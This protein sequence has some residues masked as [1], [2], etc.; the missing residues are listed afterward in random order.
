VL[1][2][3]SDPVTPV[4]QPYGLPA[5]AG[6][7]ENRRP[8]PLD[9]RE[10]L[11]VLRRRLWIV[12]TAP[13]VL[14]VLAAV[15]VSVVTPLYT[16]TSTVLID[17]RRTNVDIGSQQVLTNFGTDEASNESQVLLIQSSAVLRRVVDTL[18]LTQD[19]EFAPAPG[20]L[21][22]IRSLLAR[23]AP[24]P[25]NA[26][27][28]RITKT[29]AALRAQVKV[30]RQRTT[31]LVDINVRSRDAAKATAIANAVADAYFL[32]QVRSKYEATKIAASWL[33]QQIEDVKNRVLATDKAVADFRN[34]NNLTES[35]GVTVTDQQITDLNNRLI[36]A[37]VQAAEARAKFEQ[38]QKIAS[39]GDDPGSVAEALSSDTIAQLRTRYADLAR[40]EADLST[41]YGARHPAVATARAQLRDTQR[42][43]S[44]EVQ[45]ILQG[46]RHIYEVA[47]AREASLQGSLNALQGV[48]NEA[49]QAQ[50]RLRELQREAQANRT[51][52]ESFLARYKEMSA[53]ESLEMPDSRIVTRASVPLQPSFPNTTLT[54]ALA[55]LV[56]LGLGSV[57][58]M[59][60]DYFDRR[61]KTFEQ[62]ETASGLTG[63]AAIP[64]IGSKDLAR[65]A[66]QGRHAL[67]DYD[68]K[69]TRLLPPALQPPLLRYA[70]EEPTSI[71]AESIRA[72]RLAVQRAGRAK[73]AQVVM[74]T[75]AI[76]GEGKTVVAANL[77]LSLAI[78]GVRT[79]L[80]DGDL[81]NPELT[82]ALC[83][84]AGQGLLEVATGEIPLHEAILTEPETRLSILPA[85][86]VRDTSLSTEFVFSEGM[87]NILGTLRQHFD[88]IIIDS[89]P[90]LP[91]VDGRALAEYADCIL[92][93][94]G[95][96]RTTEDLVMR[97][98]ELLDSV[99]HRILGAV[100]TRVD[101]AKL[102]LYDYSSPSYMTSYDYSIEARRGTAA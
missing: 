46:R 95:W 62:V 85:S 82:C 97:S 24:P 86:F 36:E 37:R 33:N 17:P 76:D 93:T 57:L 22:R 71:F 92:F 29:I 56:G 48:S 53:Q 58:A 38:V 13:L 65:L 40:N 66:K 26:E 19:P 5:L 16:A 51:L 3:S 44:D 39:A 52:Y 100:L 1:Q 91:L 81:R 47:A 55:L 96:D 78:V 18:N 87:E 90:L 14:L 45:R 11:R 41:R 80:V 83:P 99:Y 61:V 59:V 102:R 73:P 28:A 42:L 68:P 43:I 9:I 88:V 35:Q 54:L 20:L 6:Q 23:P 4:Q 101:L 98:V 2:R 94:V 70:I 10:I 75:S 34:A 63:L 77:A 21:D 64:Q 8:H 72:I 89:P 67:G 32:E 25:S 50:I 31:F 15:F 69:T 74:V 49:G 30:A 79:L 84:R 60:S 7:A 12:L 27:D